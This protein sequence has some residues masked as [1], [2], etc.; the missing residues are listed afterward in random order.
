MQWMGTMKE[1]LKT[2]L[3]YGLFV[4][5][6]IGWV[7]TN[8]LERSRNQMLE[9]INFLATDRDS[10]LTLT[11]GLM[12]ELK[13]KGEG[14]ERKATFIPPEGKVVVYT[15]KDSPKVY[16]KVYNKGFTFR[17]GVGVTYWKQARLGFN[18]KLFYWGKYGVVMHVDGQAA[19]LGVSRYVEDL[20]PYW[21]PKNVEIFVA[22]KV[23]T[24][25]EQS[26]KLSI[27]VRISL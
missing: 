3:I 6:A 8:R 2:Y 26:G 10:Q 15:K 12:V 5:F 23:L 22:Y 20:I 27:G 17:P 16:T 21:R 25:T 13:R 1:K 19:A 18:S 4:L 24:F 7:Y 11:Q 14:V 9:K